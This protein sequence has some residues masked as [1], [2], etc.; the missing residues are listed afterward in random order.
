MNFKEYLKHLSIVILG[1]VIAFWISNIGVR[2]K[3]RAT[4]KQVLITIMNEVKDNNE[5]IKVTILNLDTLRT[6]FTRVNSKNA[7]SG[8][9]SIN[10]QNLSVN[11]IG[12]ETAKYTGILK[13]LNYKLVSKIVA[14]YESQK[15]IKE[16]DKSISDDLLLLFK[17]KTD[18]HPDF[19]YLLFQVGL[20]IDN[21]ETLD[22]EQKVL[23]ENLRLF[24]EIKS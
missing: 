20:L 19:D 8:P 2:I 12:Y 10:Y 14:N 18:K 7:I 24:L 4:Q 6:T 22:T 13:D 17:N 23:I 9:L 11:N 1:I 3:E 15:W 16:L 21:L 5:N